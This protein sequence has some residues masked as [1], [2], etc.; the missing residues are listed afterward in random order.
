MTVPFLIDLRKMWRQAP[1]LRRIAATWVKY[2]PPPEPG[3]NTG[4]PAGAVSIDALKAMFPN[5]RL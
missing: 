2:K 1:P 3:E 4:G 5:G